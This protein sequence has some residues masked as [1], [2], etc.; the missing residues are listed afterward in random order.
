MSDDENYY[1]DIFSDKI[2]HSL[3]ICITASLFVAHQHSKEMQRMIPLKQFRLF[4]HLS[5]CVNRKS[6]VA[7]FNCCNLGEGLLKV[8]GSAEKW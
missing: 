8:T 7:H 5:G 4:V 6:Y 2:C 3:A 1:K